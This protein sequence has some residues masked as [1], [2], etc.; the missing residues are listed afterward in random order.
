[1]NAPVDERSDYEAARQ[2]YEKATENFQAGR[3]RDDK[4]Y[5]DWADGELMAATRELRRFEISPGI[6]KPEYLTGAAA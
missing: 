6:P 2:R 4:A 3:R 1:V 5:L